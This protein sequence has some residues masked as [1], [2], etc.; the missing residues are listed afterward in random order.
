MP[1]SAGRRLHVILPSK[2]SELPPHSDLRPTGKPRPR[3]RTRGPVF[4]GVAAGARPRKDGAASCGRRSGP[5]TPL[6]RWK[7]NE[8]LPQKA[9]DVM[10]SEAPLRSLPPKFTRVSARKLAAG[11]WSLGHIDS[12]GGACGGVGE[13]RRTRPG[14]EP[15]SGYQQVE[16]LC[17]PR[18]TDLHTYKSKNH[19]F[20]SPVSVLSPKY[21][22]IHKQFSGFP[23]SALEKAT[24]WDPGSSMT[25]EEVYRFYSQLKLLEDQGLNSASIISSLRTEL[26]ETHARVSELETER[27][28]AKKKLDQFLKRLAEEKA[29][30]RNREHEKVRAIIEAMKADLDRERKKRQKIE[31]IHSKLVNE[32]AEA[33]LT[34]KKLLQDYEKERKAREL[35]EEVC[36]EL[37]K[38]IG[39]DKAEVEAVKIEA[40]KI[41]EEVEME[42]RM[43][44]MAEVWREERVQ[45]KLIDAK[46]TLQERYSQMMELKADLDS[47][48]AATKSMPMDVE[49]VGKAELLKDKVNLVNVEDI[50]EF[51][52]QP[53]PDS[54]DIYAVFK[55]LQLRQETTGR[56]IQFQ[57]CS[58]HSLRSHGSK[59]NEASPETDVFLEHHIA[60]Q[61]QDLIDSNEDAEDESD[62]ETMSHAEE[63]ASEPSV[64]DYCKESNADASMSEVE[65]KESRD[66][67]LDAET[68]TEVCSINSKSRK[69]VPSICR[70]WRSSTHD[71]AEVKPG[72]LSVSDGRISNGTLASNNGEDYKKHSVSD[73]NRRL[74]KGGSVSNETF[75]PN[76][77]T[78]DIGLS[79]E[80]IGQWSSPDS[81]NSHIGTKGCIEWPRSSQKHNLKAKLMEARMESGKVQLRHV[82]KQ[83]I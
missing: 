57:P 28:S 63:Q 59:I 55:D 24:K 27:K 43:L 22:D 39:E 77:G 20:T 66:D 67:K 82:L 79:P 9:E 54:E 29:L 37:V 6:L 21:G 25:A 35:V 41:R 72:R 52:Y 51:A 81:L 31:I 10:A 80:S 49:L 47:F 65:W 71:I 46:L 61:A 62:W 30:W 73:T 12:G 11:I 50:K 32:L 75:S 2:D 19:E 69:K 74:T 23:S 76:T 15:V 40:M 3:R 70:L 38:E 58:G 1:T 18:S 16:L 45:M 44:Q 64:N 48:L 36:D 42:K 4:P 13:G 83:K 17:N 60:E 68:V 34:A 14:F 7:F 8:K 78:G 26:E 53:P 56:D 33:R 5:N